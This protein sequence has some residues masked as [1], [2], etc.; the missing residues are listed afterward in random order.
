MMGLE[1]LA[2][3][4]RINFENLMKSSF[5]RRHGCSMVAECSRKLQKVAGVTSGLPYDCRTPEPLVAK[6]GSRLERLAGVRCLSLGATRTTWAD[7]YS[8]KSGRSANPS[9]HGTSYTALYQR[10][11]TCIR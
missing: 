10:M 6:R 4:M 1:P 8:V 3:Y 7:P 11:T 5:S 2:S 9:N